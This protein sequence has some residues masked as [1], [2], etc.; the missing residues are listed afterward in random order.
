MDAAVRSATS[1]LAVAGTS[2]DDAACC[3]PLFVSPLAAAAASASACAL[4]LLASC[5]AARIVISSAA[6]AADELAEGR[7]SDP[8]LERNEEEETEDE[9]TKPRL[10]TLVLVVMC[11]AAWL[12]R[13]IGAAEA[14]DEEAVAGVG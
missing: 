8:R 14:A 12:E 7:S 2:A 1:G 3:S 6:A 4:F 9:A 11:R 10:N 13:K 5:S